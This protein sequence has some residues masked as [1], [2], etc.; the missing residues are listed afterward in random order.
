LGNSPQEAP[1]LKAGERLVEAMHMARSRAALA[2]LDENLLLRG[3]EPAARAFNSS[4]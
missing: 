2:Q 4:A 1:S 3:R